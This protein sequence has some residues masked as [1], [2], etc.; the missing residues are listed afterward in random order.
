LRDLVLA[1]APERVADVI[2][3]YLEIALRHLPEY[4]DEPAPVVIGNSSNPL[5]SQYV[6]KIIALD[7]EG[8]SRLIESRVTDG[9]S[10]LDMYV[11]VLQPAQRQIGRLWQIN[12][13][14]VAVEHYATSTTQR[15]LNR[16][17]H[18]LPRRR[19]R[20]A[21]LVGLCPQGEH[22][23]LG[24]QMVCDLCRLDGW[25]THFVGANTPTASALAM[26]TK[27]QPDII[28]ISMTTLMA[29]GNTSELIA[30]LKQALPKAIILAGGYAASLGSD[31]WKSLGAHAYAADAAEAIVTVNR[32]LRD[33]KAGAGQRKT[34]ERLNSR[35]ARSES[36]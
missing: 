5:I 26:V 1:S 24:L 3:G 6:E 31:L 14:S 20:G 7:S 13:I 19:T 16:I 32:I 4:P 15:I 9:D 8:A 10:V 23:C 36:D 30:G 18:S 21:R 22:H 28:G 35:T 2:V 27:L 11:N 17:S 34:A 29:F 25:E 12:S 33:R